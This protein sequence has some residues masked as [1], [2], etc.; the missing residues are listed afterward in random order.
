MESQTVDM[1]PSP[2]TI[3]NI[4]K[5][6]ASNVSNSSAPTQTFEKLEPLMTQDG[7]FVDIGRLIVVGVAGAV[8]GV[9]LSHFALTTC[10][11]V[12]IEVPVGYYNETLT[13]H[14]GMSEFSSLDSVIFGSSFGCISYEDQYYGQEAPEFAKIMSMLAMVFGSI[15]TLIVWLYNFTSSTTVIA[16]TLARMSATAAALFQ[17]GT[18]QF[19]YSQV[20]ED[21]ACSIGTGS[22]FSFIAGCIYAYMAFEMGRNSPV[23]RMIPGMCKELIAKGDTHGDVDSLGKEKDSYYSAPELV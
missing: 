7:T 20:C 6:A 22:F 19:F 17:F 16:W 18:L 2:E 21:N 8:G 15:A 13:A 14:A 1:T 10:D 4:T 5:S 11:F 12:S 23:Q 9:L 3:I